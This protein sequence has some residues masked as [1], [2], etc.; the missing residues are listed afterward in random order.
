LT[1]N[2]AAVTIGTVGAIATSAPINLDG[3]ASLTLTGANTLNGAI[4]FNNTGGTSNPTLATGGVLTLG[5]SI[6][7]T[8]DSFST[9]PT[10]SG[11]L[12]FAGVTR[13]IT[14]SGLA[15]LD[16][17]VSAIIQN[18]T[19]TKDGSGMLSLNAQ[20]TFAGGVKCECR[21]RCSRRFL[22]AELGDPCERSVW[23]RHAVAGEQY[24]KLIGVASTVYNPITLSSN[25]LTIGGVIAANNLTLNGAISFGAGQSTVLVESPVVVGTLGA[26]LGGAFSLAKSGPGVLALSNP[27]NNYSGVTYVNDGVL[28]ASVANAFS[29]NSQFNVAPIG[30]VDSNGISSVIGSLVGTGFVTNNS[31]PQRH[32]EQGSTTP[33]SRSR[34]VSAPLRKPAP[35]SIWTR[36]ARER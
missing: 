6:T 25:T 11:T 35:P 5:G 21:R 22:H 27:A 29:V 17:V 36:S 3:G 33:T 15:P 18:G 8:N 10:I 1:L 24:T 7:A 16:L 34:A 32:C 12:D 30:T 4:T 31:R 13:N 26:A 9:I 23:N 19:L 20:N 14:T 2:N 28:R